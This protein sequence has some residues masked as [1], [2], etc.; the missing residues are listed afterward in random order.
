[1]SSRGYVCAD[2]PLAFTT[3][4]QLNYHRLQKHGD[5]Q[6]TAATYAA[7]QQPETPKEEPM[8][9]DLCIHNSD[10]RAKAEAELAVIQSKLADT[11]A[12]LQSVKLAQTTH[13][14]GLCNDEKCESCAAQAADI[15]MATMRQA[16]LDGRKAV[17]DELSTALTWAGG[18]ALAEKIHEITASWLTAGR[19]EPK[20]EP[21]LVIVR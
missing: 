9:C 11:T 8:S 6:L 10:T 16:T 18:P 3:V 17:L 15:A 20:A 21:G 5:I 12:E 7:L 2:C 14:P 19:P 13:P 4:A 1:M